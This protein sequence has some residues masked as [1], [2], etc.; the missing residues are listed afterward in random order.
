MNSEANQN[1][2]DFQDGYLVD[3]INQNWGPFD[4]TNMLVIEP[5]IFSNPLF[6]VKFAGIRE[7]CQIDSCLELEC[8]ETNNIP[9]EE[10]ELNWANFAYERENDSCS[11]EKEIAPK[12][13]KKYD[14]QSLANRNLKLNL[15][16]GLIQFLEFKRQRANSKNDK[17]N[18]GVIQKILD[19]VLEKQNLL[20]S[21]EGWRDIL[22]NRE[23]GK[24]IRKLCK[25]FFGKSFA[26]TYVQFAKIKKEYKPVYYKKIECFKEGAKNPMKLKPAIYNKYI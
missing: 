2:S 26:R 4:F 3:E 10:T 7:N 6:P 21:F 17:K 13:N 15:G 9:F 23:M 8:L 24:D 25:S 12:K 11:Q 5:S 19:F 14:F 22:M 1:T 16:T 20:S 18:A